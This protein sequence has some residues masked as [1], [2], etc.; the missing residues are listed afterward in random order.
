MVVGTSFAGSG[1]M[2]RLRGGRLR[3]GR[4]DPAGLLTAVSVAAA[5]KSPRDA[6]VRPGRYG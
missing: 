3:Q 4:S 2:A 5:T 6:A 1:R